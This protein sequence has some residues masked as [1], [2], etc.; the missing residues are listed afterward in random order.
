MYRQTKSLRFSF[1]QLLKAEFGGPGGTSSTYMKKFLSFLLLALLAGSAAQAEELTICDGGDQSSTIPVNG[2]WADTE[3]TISQMIYPAELLVDMEGGT[4]TEVTFYTIAY[5]DYMQG[6]DLPSEPNN[7]I[8]F[9]N[10]IIR[11]AFKTVDEDGFSEVVAYTDATPVATTIPEYGNMS[12]T[13]VLD[14]PFDYDGG[15]LLVEAKV[16][17]P[18]DWGVTYFYGQSFDYNTSYYAY[19]NYNN[20]CVEYVTNFLPMVTFTYDPVTPPMEQTAAP[21]ITG[22][23]VDGFQGFGITIEPEDPDEPSTIYYRFWYSDY[24]EW[25]EW[26]EYTDVLFFTE[27]GYYHIEAYAVADGKLPSPISGFEFTVTQ[28]SQTPAPVITGYLID[29]AKYEY[30]IT[31]TAG[32]YSEIYYRIQHLNPEAWS[33]WMEYTGELVFIGPGNYR[34][35]A[36]A[37]EPGMLSSSVVSYDFTIIR[38]GDVDGN[39]KLTISDVTALINILLSGGEYPPEADVNGDGNVNINDVTDLIHILLSQN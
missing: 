21:V 39:D 22:F 30:G 28:L 1:I 24:E 26:M 8:N 35:Q 36:Y 23:T 37:I 27:P 34:I 9:K 33:D 3:G 38:Y 7:Y 6:L 19:N 11:L 32:I 2:I 20:H 31:I 10:S 5:Y 25:T 16:I 12:L 13:F 17:E 4:I 15:N 14:E 18:G 29:A